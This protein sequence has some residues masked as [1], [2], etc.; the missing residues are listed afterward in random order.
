MNRKSIGKRSIFGRALVICAILVGLGILVFK[1]FEPVLIYKSGWAPFARIDQSNVSFEAPSPAWKD[2]ASA[3]NAA[4]IKRYQ[5][6]ENPALSAAVAIDGVLVW[7]GAIGYANIEAGS[8]IGVDDRFR[9]GSSSKPVTAIAIG[10]LLDAGKLDLDIPMIVVD[11]SLSDGMKSITLRQVMSHRAG[12]RDYGMCWCF[13]AWEHLNQRAF[14]SVRDSVNVIDGDRLLSVLGKQYAY[15]SLGYNLAGLAVEKAS[16]KTFQSYLQ[17]AIFDPLGMA[18]SGLDSIPNGKSERVGFYD[19][20][21]GQYKR[22]FAVN[23]SIW[24]PSGGILSTPGDMVRLGSAMLDNRLLSSATRQKLVK[25]P[26][27][28]RSNGGEI[29]ALGW[30]VGDWTL[31]NR[32]VLKSYHHNGTAVGST[33]VFVIFPEKKMVISVMANKGAEP[34]DE[35]MATADE[36][37]MAF[38]AT[39]SIKK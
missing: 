6:T 3:A 30:R 21:N 15:T 1:F 33:S 17:T 14:A 32:M 13:P 23:N 37:I 26:L 25:V 11:P 5:K 9:L 38:V 22:A 16:G 34:T 35:L 10:T 7:R 29:Y 8:P 36:I 39:L 2:A 28:G 19:L 12:I 20:E 24:W 4:L 27:L 31:P 18:R